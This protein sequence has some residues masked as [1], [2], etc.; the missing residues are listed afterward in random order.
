MKITWR[1]WTGWSHL[2]N[3]DT[4]QSFILL[5]AIKKAAIHVPNHR[6]SVTFDDQGNPGTEEVQK[7]VQ[8]VVM[9]RVRFSQR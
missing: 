2:K 1:G 5:I 7:A 9:V 6:Y 4:G 8:T 3:L